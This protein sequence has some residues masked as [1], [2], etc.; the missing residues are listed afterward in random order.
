M[1]CL[2]G[3]GIN[4][5]RKISGR[6]DVLW[7][8]RS[9]TATKVQKKKETPVFRIRIHVGDGYFHV[10]EIYVS[11]LVVIVNEKTG[12]SPGPGCDGERNWLCKN[13]FCCDPSPSIFFLARTGSVRKQITARSIPG[14]GNFC[15]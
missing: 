12:R 2:A 7:A 8:D 6:I 3:I 13:I 5:P 4:L 14:P 1:L 15:R 10:G 11:M 9:K